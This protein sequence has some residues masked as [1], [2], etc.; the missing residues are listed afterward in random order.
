MLWCIAVQVAVVTNQDIRKGGLANNKQLW[1]SY[2]IMI[3]TDK[4]SVLILTSAAQGNVSFQKNGN[5]D[6][7]LISIFQYRGTASVSHS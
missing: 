3:I 4:Q 5:R 2:S 7:P 6:N 1:L